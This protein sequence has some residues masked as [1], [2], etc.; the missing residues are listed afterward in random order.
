MAIPWACLTFAPL[1]GAPW[2]SGFEDGDCVNLVNGL[3]FSLA[4]VVKLNGLIMEI[5]W[6]L[7][8]RAKQKN[9]P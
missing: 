9:A 2:V 4:C 8:E 7:C 3:D 5:S 1:I 6:G